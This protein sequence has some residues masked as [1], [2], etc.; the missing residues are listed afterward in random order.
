MFDFA[1]MT[2]TGIAGQILGFVAMGIAM[3]SFQARRSKYIM[4]C[5]G[6]A[7]LFWVTHYFLLGSVVGAALNAVAMLRNFAYMMR[8]KMPKKA[9]SCIPIITGIAFVIITAFTYSGPID[10]LPFMGCILATI[11]FFMKSE[12][13]L[14][15]L[16][17]AVSVFWLIYNLTQGSIAGALNET[18][19]IVSIII[20]LIRYR[21][22]SAKPKKKAE[23][24][25]L[26]EDVSSVK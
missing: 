18:L 12:K 23:K 3:M 16:S 7:A 2:G 26:R 19:A 24:L 11:A 5:Q 21:K 25:D 10:I 8:D 13:L 6:I 15:I 9:F 20:A 22:Y 17:M 14:R 4:L 1:N